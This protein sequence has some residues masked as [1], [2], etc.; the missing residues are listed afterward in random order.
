MGQVGVEYRMV[1]QNEMPDKGGTFGEKATENPP[2]EIRELVV[3]YHADVYRYAYRLAGGVAD[4]EDL[5]QQT[6]LIAQQRLAQLR[7][8]SKAIGWLFAI[9]RSCFLKSHRRTRPVAAGAIELDVDSI[10]EI[11]SDDE[12]DRERLQQGINHLPD[13]FKIVLLMFYFEQL[14]Y[15]DIAERLDVSIGTVMSRLSRAKGR[16]R[17]FLLAAADEAEVATLTKRT[18]P[19]QPSKDPMT[20]GIN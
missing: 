9:T 10:P 5:T 15:K 1:D 3:Q 17:G 4:A 8:P 13:S 19:A 20:F 2:M 6:F 14:S 18:E 12:I 16:L 7:E 11:G